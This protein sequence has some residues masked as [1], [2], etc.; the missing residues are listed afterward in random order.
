MKNSNKVLSNIPP[1]V[2][3]EVKGAHKHV[4]KV[5]FSDVLSW[6]ARANILRVLDVSRVVAPKNQD[7][8]LL[9]YS[10]KYKDRT[11]KTKV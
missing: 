1:L 2:N 4:Q 10:N 3:G 6:S 5:Y 7:W 9:V 11:N 8:I